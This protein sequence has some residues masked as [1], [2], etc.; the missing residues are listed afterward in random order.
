[1]MDDI[2]RSFTWW[3]NALNGVRGEIDA[4]NPRAGFY[5]SKRKDK[6]LHGV[7]IWYDSNSGDLR[8]Q[9][10]GRDVDD[11][12]AR[13]RWPHDSRRPISEDVFW[14]FRDT[15]LWKD[16][17]GAAQAP[18]VETDAEPNIAIA[19]EIS[20]AKASAAKY[21]KVESDEEMT[22]AQSLR[23]KLQELAGTAD[24]ARVAEKEPH[25]TAAEEVDAKWQPMIK[26]AKAAADG[27]RKAMQDWNDFKLEQQRKAD[28][29][30]SRRA[31]EAAQ[32]GAPVTPLP[33]PNAPPPSVQVSG[34]GGR[35]AHVGVKDVV[36]AI[37]IDL[38]FKQFRD[39]P[40]VEDLLMSL[41]QRAIDAGIPVPGA[42][43]EKK[44]NIR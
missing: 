13:E 38:A 23:S 36:T 1:M 39:V 11:L 35:A 10:D 14:H 27:I 40:S 42:T 21:A 30:I 44:S 26:V 43:V 37:D 20:D 3:Q 7:A 33:K 34:G 24:K 9:E 28:Q 32:M 18:A 41:A 8:Y 19:K 15:G 2:D 16:V 22:L 31:I 4:D 12:R 6:S 25:K 17:D 5:R 29:E